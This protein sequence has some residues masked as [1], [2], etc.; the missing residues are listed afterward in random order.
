MITTKYKK[1][2]MAITSER[3]RQTFSEGGAQEN[4]QRQVSIIMPIRH[5]SL[6]F[7]P[8]VW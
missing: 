2:N 3:L 6:L 4:P 7:I 8:N 5:K 1:Y